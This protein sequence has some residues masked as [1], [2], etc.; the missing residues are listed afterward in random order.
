M[1]DPLPRVR[2][3]GPSTSWV[4]LAPDRSAAQIPANPSTAGCRRYRSSRAARAV[5]RSSRAHGDAPPRRSGGEVVGHHPMRDSTGHRCSADAYAYAPP[6]TCDR[7]ASA[8]VLRALM[9]EWSAGVA[10]AARADAAAHVAGSFARRRPGRVVRPRRTGAGPVDPHATD[11][12]IRFRGR[13]IVRTEVASA[14]RGA[15]LDLY[16]NAVVD[17][18][19]GCS[20]RGD[21]RAES[22]RARRS[23]FP[24]RAHASAMA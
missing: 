8:G 7:C 6:A 9:R 21:E 18:K 16:D 13:T 12:L 17:E 22:R 4:G 19:K 20:R 11:P 23:A 2:A 1:P 5:E 14:S 24:S 3:C 15:R 10:P